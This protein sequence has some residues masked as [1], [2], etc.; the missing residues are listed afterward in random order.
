MIKSKKTYFLSNANK[1]ASEELEKQFSLS[2]G[3]HEKKGL[4]R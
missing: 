2:R 3:A 1:K 4:G